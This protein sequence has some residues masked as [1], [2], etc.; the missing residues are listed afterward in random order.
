MASYKLDLAKRSEVI[1][2]KKIRGYTNNRWRDLAYVSESTLKRFL[3]STPIEAEN[4]IGILNAIGIETWQEFVDWDEQCGN[5]A[6]PSKSVEESKVDMKALLMGETPEEETQKSA[7]CLVVDFEPEQT[8]KVESLINH[9]KKYLLE[10]EVDH[11]G[12]CIVLSGRF[13]KTKETL[14][15]SIAQNLKKFSVACEVSIQPKSTV[16]LDVKT[17]TGVKSSALRIKGIQESLMPVGIHQ[18]QTN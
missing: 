15:E 2:V 18:H 3:N 10:V 6:K 9:L 1:A 13:L 14:V 12:M 7:I 11:C 5:G 17:T 16:E 8:E 4:F